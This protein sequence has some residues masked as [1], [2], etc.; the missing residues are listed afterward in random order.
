[1]PRVARTKSE[2]GIYH[3][4]IRGINKQDIFLDEQDKHKFKKELKRTKEKYNYNLYA[5]CLMPNHVHLEVKDNDNCINKL[6][7]GIQISY[8]KYFN[9]KYERVGHLFQNRYLSRGVESENDMINLQRYIHQNP[10]KAG[11]C[12]TEDYKWSSYK[13]YQYNNGITDKNDILSLFGK[14]REIALDNFK[15]YNKYDKKLYTEDWRYYYEMSN[16]LSDEELVD[17]IKDVIQEENIYKILQYKKDIRDKVLKRITN[18]KGVT[19]SQLA[20][21]LG[22]NRKIVS[23]LK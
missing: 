18:V 7:Q 23:R 5:Y 14:D 21:V 15:N 8:S 16:K 20:R 3:C 9:Q 22:I 1:M 2:T 12:K 10:E 19:Y 13:E 6:M 17:V 11:I 4:M